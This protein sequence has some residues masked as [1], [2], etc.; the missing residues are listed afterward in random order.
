[1]KTIILFRAENSM[2][3]LI[4]TFWL[5]HPGH[6]GHALRVGLCRGSLRLSS[7][8]VSGFAGSFVIPGIP[9][10]PPIPDAAAFIWLSES[11]RKLPD[12][13]TRSPPVRPDRIWMRS[14]SRSPVFTCL[15][16][17]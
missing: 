7:L 6:V 3:P 4:I 2:M 1:M 13:T 15:G 11:I 10:I 17:K 5:R 14:P 8:A 12:V 9:A 16:S